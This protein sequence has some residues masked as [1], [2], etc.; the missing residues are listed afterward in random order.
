MSEA[1]ILS[2]VRSPLARAH[3][4]SFVNTRID[5]IAAQ[6]LAAALTA[7][8]GLDPAAVEDLLVG[9]AF[10]EGEQGLNVSRNI[11]LLAG[12]PSTTAAATINRYCASSMEAVA[13]AARAVACGD[14]DL[15]VAGGIE[16]MTHVPIGGFNT[17]LNERLAT[18]G[19]P[20]VY[21]PMGLTAE[22]VAREYGISR[23][24]QD[25]FALMSH[26]KAIAAQGRGEFDA[27][28]VP[29]EANATDGARAMVASDEGP[30]PDTSMEALANLR[31]AFLEGGTVTAGN[32][33][34]M[35]DGAAMVVIA[36]K[37]FAKRIGVKPLV[38]IRA[39]AVAGVAPELMGT[40]PIAAVPKA[41]ARA[42]MKLRNVDIVEL[43]EAF[44]SQAIACVRELGIDESRLNVS[45]GA[46]ALGHPL[47]ASGA[48]I[49]T[50]LVHAMTARGARRGLAT[51]CVG[52]GQGM[53]MVLER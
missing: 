12:L 23:E 17:S 28:I 13:Q 50:T 52:G 33:S 51:M 25:R 41:L 30:R 11:A 31:P 53:A 46:I 32:S 49:V 5:D 10:P 26:R 44:A 15:I 42:R 19:A 20:D 29:V 22:N 45:G 24:E 7:V 40:G 3:K 27:E 6:V 14:G 47:G 1:V 36:S 39:T 9:C 2:C 43:N 48:R 21:I 4:G 8:P 37:R 38:R 16:S 34:P 18:D 35:T